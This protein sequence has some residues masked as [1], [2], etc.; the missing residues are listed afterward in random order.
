MT[1]TATS[2]ALIND[3]TRTKSAAFIARKLQAAERSIREA[4]ASIQ[5]A[6]NFTESNENEPELKTSTMKAL[7]GS[8]DITSTPLGMEVRTWEQNTAARR[9]NQR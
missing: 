2:T 8:L 3:S 6:I 5:E 9:S 1:N 7:I 4:R